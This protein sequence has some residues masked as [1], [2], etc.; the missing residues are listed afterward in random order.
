MT[1]KLELELLNYCILQATLKGNQGRHDIAVRYLE[2]AI[3]SVNALKEMQ[4]K[5]D[6]EVVE[7]EVNLLLKQIEG[8][9]LMD[10]LK[11][12]ISR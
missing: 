6:Y 9:H 2:D 11:R 5:R 12:R 1:E 8:T 10:E 4:R 7:T 3:K